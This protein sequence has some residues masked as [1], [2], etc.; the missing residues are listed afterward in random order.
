MVGSFILKQIKT[1][2]VEASHDCPSTHHN[3]CAPPGSIIGFRMLAPSRRSMY[4][5]FIQI[6]DALASEQSLHHSFKSGWGI[7]QPESPDCEMPLSLPQE[8]SCLLCI[9]GN[10]ASNHCTSSGSW[11][12]W[13]PGHQQYTALG[14]WAVWL[15]S[16]YYSSPRN[17]SSPS[18]S[19]EG[20]LVLPV[21]CRIVGW[22]LLLIP[23]HC[24]PH[25]VKT[26]REEERRW[27]DIRTAVQNGWSLYTWWS[28]LFS[29]CPISLWEAT[30]LP[31]SLSAFLARHS[32]YLATARSWVQDLLTVNG[33]KA[34]W[35]LQCWVTV[36]SL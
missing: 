26:C 19:S 28:H 23:P 10:T 27:M 30:A 12:T 21:G 9:P 14:N 31:V 33:R 13:S 15:Y 6:S 16:G 8:Q 3:S 7:A 1:Q 24:L 25:Q 35:L 18:S 4:Q 22:C 11:N 2:L 32:W 5:E 36:T 34:M 20:R 17:P 29:K